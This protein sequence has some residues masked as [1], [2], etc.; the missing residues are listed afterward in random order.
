MDREFTPT[1]LDKLLVDITAFNPDFDYEKFFADLKANVEELYK[2][3]QYMQLKDLFD[4]QKRYRIEQFLDLLA[5]AN[6][7]LKSEEYFEQ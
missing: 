7:V 4:K 2:R 1:E 6:E 3:L 5:E